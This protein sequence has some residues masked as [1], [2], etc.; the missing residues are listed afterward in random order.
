[1][2]QN[3]F[4]EGNGAGEYRI[5]LT[6]IKLVEV[7]LPENGKSRRLNAFSKDDYVPVKTTPG[8]KIII[9]NIFE[10]I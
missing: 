6:D 10:G 7:F 3:Q 1:M 9:E 4:F 2:W 5:V 8:L